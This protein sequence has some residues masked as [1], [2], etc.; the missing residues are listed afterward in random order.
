MLSCDIE[1]KTPSWICKPLF[2]QMTS[3]DFKVFLLHSFYITLT[4]KGKWLISAQFLLYTVL[5]FTQP[6]HVLLFSAAV[7]LQTQQVKGQSKH[8][9]SASH[10]LNTNH[11][12]SIRQQFSTLINRGCWK[13]NNLRV[14]DPPSSGGQRSRCH[15]M[16]ISSFHQISRLMRDIYGFNRHIDPLERRP[17]RLYV[18]GIIMELQTVTLWVRLTLL[19]VG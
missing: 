8:C 18:G 2:A 14:H 10:G 7:H 5:F 17:A 6:P 9:G 12:G 16:E 3:C 4:F 19:N 15:Y 13:G 11:G 1:T